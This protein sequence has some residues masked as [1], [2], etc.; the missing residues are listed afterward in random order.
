MIVRRSPE[1][2]ATTGRLGVYGSLKPICATLS[3]FA[4]V[5]LAGLPGHSIAAD[6]LVATILP[7]AFSTQVRRAPVRSLILIGTSPSFSRLAMVD[8]RSGCHQPD[9]LSPSSANRAAALSCRSGAANP[10]IKD[11]SP[12]PLTL[13]CSARSFSVGLRMS[14]TTCRLTTGAMTHH[15]AFGLA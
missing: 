13:S 14:V 1:S 7:G 2:I 15:L 9:A 6:A 11:A 12:A 4:V 3:F 5:E 10:C 8:S